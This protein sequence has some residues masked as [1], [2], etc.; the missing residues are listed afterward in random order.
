ML[1]INVFN[2]EQ[3]RYKKIKKS[4]YVVL[5]YISINIFKYYKCIVDIH[6]MML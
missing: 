6:F 4:V 5:K 3:C 2:V 1:K